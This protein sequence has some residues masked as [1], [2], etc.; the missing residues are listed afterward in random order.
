MESVSPRFADEAVQDFVETVSERI[1]PPDIILRIIVL[2]QGALWKHRARASPRSSRR[3]T[4]RSESTSWAV[5]V[6]SQIALHIIALHK[7]LIDVGI[8]E[9]AEAGQEDD[10]AQRITATFRRTLPALR[11]A[12]RWL[13][14]NIQYVLQMRSL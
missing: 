6:E 8:T 13:V 4:A 12:S 9:L 2:S 11:V 14:E 7:A 10:L 3:P 5:L 1:L